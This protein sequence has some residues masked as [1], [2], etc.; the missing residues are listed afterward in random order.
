MLNIKS[1]EARL[2]EL[3]F[4]NL[5]HSSN[6]ILKLRNADCKNII[7]SLFKIMQKNNI[8]PSDELFAATYYADCKQSLKMIPKILSIG[9]LSKCIKQNPENSSEFLKA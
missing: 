5:Y 6:R 4:N 3:I 7:E 2:V 8:K 1:I 9:T